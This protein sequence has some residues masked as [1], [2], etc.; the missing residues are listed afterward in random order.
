LD[1]WRLSLGALKVRSCGDAVR[2]VV[3][4]IADRMVAVPTEQSAYC[5]R[6]VI[7]ID[8]LWRK[9]ATDRTQTF[10]IGSELN[11]CVDGQ[12]V[13]TQ[14]EHGG[15]PGR[16]RLPRDGSSSNNTLP[17]FAILLAFTRDLNPLSIALGA[18]SKTVVQ[19]IRMAR[20]ARPPPGPVARSAEPTRVFTSLGMADGWRHV[21]AAELLVARLAESTRLLAIVTAWSEWHVWHTCAE[22]RHLRS[23]RSRGLVVHGSPSD[24]HVQ[25]PSA[26]SAVCSVSPSPKSKSKIDLGTGIVFALFGGSVVVGIKDA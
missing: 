9:S 11:V 25:T 19:T 14:D 23:Q 12:V 21:L 3:S 5:P 8:V 16:M 22:A 26:W 17:E 4:K 1:P 24:P 6:D 10:L 2:R 20:R 15:N 18:E 13:T 7:M